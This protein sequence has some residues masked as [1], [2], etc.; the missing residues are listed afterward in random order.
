MDRCPE[1]S[2]M[3]E[4]I[5]EGR[6]VVVTAWHAP[7]LAPALT[8]GAACVRDP[9][10]PTAYSC[11]VGVARFDLLL[12]GAYLPPHSSATNA[13]L[14]MLLPLSVGEPIPGLRVSLSRGRG[15]RCATMTTSD[16]DV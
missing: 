3:L 16:G 2:D 10:R 11:V 15:A 13:K 14:R 8:F 6:F 7:A 9:R 1:T 5:A 4:S 12:P